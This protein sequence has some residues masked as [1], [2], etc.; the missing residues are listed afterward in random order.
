MQ[1]ANVLLNYNALGMSSELSENI[2]NVSFLSSTFQNL[3]PNQGGFE[4]SFTLNISSL[5]SDTISLKIRAVDASE[6]FS[7]WSPILTVRLS[8]DTNHTLSPHLRHYVYEYPA[9]KSIEGTQSNENLNK[10]L[11]LIIF[12]NKFELFSFRSGDYF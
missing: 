3:K 2:L 11:I 10:I 4:E 6:N 1:D 12:G 5:E 9:G 7:P 8:N